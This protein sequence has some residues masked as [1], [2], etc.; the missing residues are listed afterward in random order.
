MRT[1]ILFFGLVPF[2][3]CSQRPIQI[4][5]ETDS[6]IE[7]AAGESFTVKLPSAIGTGYTWE[8]TEPVDSS[9]LTLISKEYKPSEEDADNSSGFD[10]FLF[11][12][13][14]KGSTELNFRYVRP[15]KKDAAD[16]PDSRTKSF[17]VMIR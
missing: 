7:V 6:T 1:L 16:D 9:T 3:S 14:N 2:W 11:K 5:L 15:W 12:T 17:K 10:V 4:F 8:M 13:Q